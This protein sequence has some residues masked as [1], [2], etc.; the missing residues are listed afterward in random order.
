[1]T[2]KATFQTS[3]DNPL[4]GIVLMIGFC[5]V[6][7]FGDALI[8]LLGQ[9]VSLITV[10]IARFTLQALLL[11]PIVWWQKHG[12]AE[13]F[14]HSPKVWR[15]LAW[16]TFMHAASIAGMYFGLQYMPLADT[17]AIAFIYPILMLLVGHIVLKEQVGYHRVGA[18]LIGFAGTLMVVQ[19]NFSAVGFHALWPIGVAVTFVV[20][21]LVTRQMSRDID[22]VS[23]QAMSGVMA[24]PLLL[25]V[26]ILFGGE[27]YETFDL[28]R[29]DYEGWWLLIGAGV[30]GTYAHLLMTWAL[31]YAPSATLAPMQ[32]LE[33][34][35]ATLIGWLIFSDFPNLLA[36]LGI[37]VTISTGLYIVYREQKAHN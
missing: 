22:P 6:I 33:L 36:S 5:M 25:T 29:P 19:P 16:R 9:S 2:G 11:L 24:I 37:M 17:V 4:L 30:V 34:P 28:T 3:G 10:L 35:F 15:L 20:F 7:P 12:L 31:R 26:M 8:K 32:Y 13:A 18:S 27:G 14:S 21:A 1:M 23:I